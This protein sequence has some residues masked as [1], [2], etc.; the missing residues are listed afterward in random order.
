MKQRISLAICGLD[1]TLDASLR[2]NVRP[3]RLRGSKHC[4]WL[5]LSVPV[6]ALLNSPAAAQVSTEAP[7]SPALVQT[8][9]TAGTP[10]GVQPD[11]G[12]RPHSEMTV[13]PAPTSV[14]VPD[15]LSHVAVGGWVEAYYAWSFNKPSNRIID[16][17]GFDNRHNS[18]NLSNA[19]LDI[20]GEWEGVHADLTL[21]WGSTPATY[22][23]GEPV[24][25]AVGTGV[26]LQD[27]TLWRALQKANFGYRIP[28]GAGLDVSAGLFLSPVGVE[29]LAVKDNWLYSRTNLFCGYPFYH[30]GLRASYPLSDHVTLVGWVVNGW[31]T[32]LDNNDEKSF[33]TQAQITLGDAFQGSMGYVGGVERPRGAP[34][35]R[36]WRHLLDL[37]GTFAATPWLA[38]QG[39]TTGG[40]EQN[41]FGTSAFFG[42]ILAM[43]VTPVDWLA[44]AL[45]GDFFWEKVATNDSGT[46]SAIFWPVEWM[47][48]FT[49]GLRLTPQ[50][51]LAVHLEYRR[52]W[53]AGNAFFRGQVE[54]DGLSTPFVRNADTQDTATLGATAWF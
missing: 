48:S 19:V 18:A 49:A 9:D 13:E 46:A 53:A 29:S 52:D 15:R 47:S 33:I 37:N 17:R 12:T 30:T 3:L 45:R 51:H 50:D 42:G 36:A 1:S 35:G 26:G 10:T 4:A 23:L 7:P 39:Q 25:P 14:I 6:A 28:V 11:P 34:E 24:A 43:R 38:F 2:C 16:L 44:V 5:L 40:F 8:S 20:A 41:E 54:G 21:Q 31:N 27:A 32:L 22:Y